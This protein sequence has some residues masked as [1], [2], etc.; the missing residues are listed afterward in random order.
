ML[1]RKC[2]S[3][4]VV[5]R[6][7]TWTNSGMRKLESTPLS[8]NMA[9]T[10]CRCKWQ[11]IFTVLTFNCNY[12]TLLEYSRS[13]VVKKGDYFYIY[14]ST[15]IYVDHSPPIKFASLHLIF[16]MSLRNYL[17]ICFNR[18]DLDSSMQIYYIYC[19][20]IFSGDTV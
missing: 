19:Y 11:I 5:T 16:M 1:Y 8:S 15:F 18:F 12:S 17:I 10:V 9:G 6:D 14:L 3:H 4:S 7:K 20:F 2:I 13:A